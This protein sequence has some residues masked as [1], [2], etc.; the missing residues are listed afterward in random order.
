MQLIIQKIFRYKWVPAIMWALFILVICGIPG[1]MLPKQNFWQWLRF[2][3]IVHL[4]VFG[5]QYL[6]LIIPL[7]AGKYPSKRSIIIAFALS[8][9]YGCFIEVLQEHV[10]TKRSGDWRDALANS[11]GVVIGWWFHKGLPTGWWI[12]PNK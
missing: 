9:G 10:F 5:M 12:Q 6:F 8:I 2:D 1:S 4:L 11:L 7:S 3:K